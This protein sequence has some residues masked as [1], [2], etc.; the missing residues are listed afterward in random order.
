MLNDFIGIGHLTSGLLLWH[1]SQVIK[2][3]AKTE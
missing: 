2:Q 3:T 1:L